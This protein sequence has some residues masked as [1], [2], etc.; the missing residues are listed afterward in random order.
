[1]EEHLTI[2]QMRHIK[3][4]SQESAAKSVGLSREHLGRIEKDPEQLRKV[5]IDTI[6]NLVNHYGFSIGDVYFFKQ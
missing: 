6:L 5:K 2:K 4:L 3:G 1:M